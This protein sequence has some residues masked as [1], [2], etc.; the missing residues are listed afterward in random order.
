VAVALTDRNA[1]IV[2]PVLSSSAGNE[3]GYTIATA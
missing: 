3:P 2:W 1:R